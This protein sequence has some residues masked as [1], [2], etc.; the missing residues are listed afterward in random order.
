MLARKKLLP[1][2]IFYG[3]I[4]I[5]VVFHQNV[6]A[7]NDSRFELNNKTDSVKV[8]Q[9]KIY[10]PFLFSPLSTQYA[11]SINY[12]D[13]D[14]NLMQANPENAWGISMARMRQSNFF[15]NNNS[16]DIKAD[17]YMGNFLFREKGLMSDVRYILGLA[18]MS[19]AGY[20]AY[21]HIQKYGFLKDKSK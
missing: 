8:I 5:A 12:N 13:E 11:P 2:L 6:F 17:L 18:S 10:N 16:N 14:F 15:L 7:Q 4:I 21:K 1:S 3:A 9:E 20:F 19:A